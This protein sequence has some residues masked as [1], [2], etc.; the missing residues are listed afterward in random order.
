MAKKLILIPWERYQTLLALEAGNSSVEAGLHH[1]EDNTVLDSSRSQTAG[2][3]GVLCGSTGEPVDG[4]PVP[5]DTGS[6]TSGPPAEL[7]VAAGD[8]N[9]TSSEQGKTGSQSRSSSPRL[10]KRSG[11]SPAGSPQRGKRVKQLPVDSPQQQTGDGGSGSEVEEEK[12]NI[13]Y[14]LVPPGIRVKKWIR[15]TRKK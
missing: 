11:E 15:W 3:T 5:S 14:S 6:R 13:D 4:T 8:G 9:S 12:K 10:G 7:C 1:P 2:V